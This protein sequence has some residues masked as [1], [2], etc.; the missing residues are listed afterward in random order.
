MPRKGPRPL[1]LRVLLA[2]ERGRFLA[3]TLDWA[4]DRSGL[5][6]P[7]RGLAVRLAYGTLQRLLYLDH[8]LAPWLRAPDRLPPEAR[9]IL[10]LGAYERLFLRTP[11]HAA[12][13]QWVGIAKAHAP[14][15]A[16]LVNA[17]LR[18]VGDRPAPAWVRASIPRFLYR[19]WQTYFGD[20]GFVPELNRP[21]PLWVT[22]L[23]GAE[24]ALRAEGVEFR[25]GPVPGSLALS[26]APLRSLAAYRRGL[27]QPQNPASLLAAQLLEAAPGERVLDLAG[28]AGL[29]AAWLAAQGARVTSYDR[30][31]RK[32]A[33][34]RRNLARLGL[35]VAFVTADLTR[36]LADTAPKVLLDAPCTGTGTL[37]RH[38]EIRYRLRPGDPQRMQTRQAALLE[39]AA[40]AV[41]PGGRLVYAVCSLTETEGE[42]VVEGF[43]Q[44]HPE[45]EAEP[46]ALPV[47]ALK[48]G[49]GAYVR[50]EAG[51]DGFYYARL[52]RR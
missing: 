38:P 49:L 25:P 28:G 46:L 35:E 41:A 39:V 22:A 7:D 21:P 10:R 44:A 11:D 26:G 5:A 23:P 48:T 52:R 19:H 37:R 16:G 18:R 40:G 14:G 6:G 9:W 51:L 43:L 12:V 24:E 45:F 33:A 30:D 31:R 17:V 15:H 42:A 34:G 2:V 27:V 13:H 4:L 20:A 36:G 47:P 50:P 8:A 3:P 29:K 32:Q 1:A